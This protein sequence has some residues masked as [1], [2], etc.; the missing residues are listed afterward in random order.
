M[1]LFVVL[2]LMA[3]FFLSGTVFGMNQ[4]SSPVVEV[5][6]EIAVEEE[7]VPVPETEHTPVSQPAVDETSSIHGAQKTASVLEAGVK[8][9]FELL[10]QVMYQI[11]QLFF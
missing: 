5:T 6:E 10:M 11:A 1:R 4:E 3:V 9:F 7:T 2:L 8:G